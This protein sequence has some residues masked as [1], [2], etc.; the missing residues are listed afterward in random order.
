MTLKNEFRG[1][2]GVVAI[3]AFR[4]AGTQLFIRASHLALTQGLIKMQRT[5]EQILMLFIPTK[6]RRSSTPRN[7]WER[8]KRGDRIPLV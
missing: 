3:A 6:M 1:V 7:R 5:A 2:V 8:C 4:G